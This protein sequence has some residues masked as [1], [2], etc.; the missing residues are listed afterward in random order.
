VRFS[1]AQRQ[2]INQCFTCCKIPSAASLVRKLFS[3]NNLHRR[4]RPFHL[5][6]GRPEG[7]ISPPILDPNSFHINALEFCSTFSPRN[8]GNF[9]P[10]VVFSQPLAR[11]VPPINISSE[12]GGLSRFSR[13]KWFSTNTL[14][15]CAPDLQNFVL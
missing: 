3:H 2:F 14:R 4:I 6:A 8:L 13:R 11:S 7:L 12:P 10:Q 1:L 9:S 5:R 15:K